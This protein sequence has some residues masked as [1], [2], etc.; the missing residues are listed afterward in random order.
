MACVTLYGLVAY[1]IFTGEYWDSQ[2]QG[3]EEAPFLAGTLHADLWASQFFLVLLWEI[4]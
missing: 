4:Q 1:A 3:I 2:P